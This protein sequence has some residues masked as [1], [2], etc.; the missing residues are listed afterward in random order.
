MDGSGPDDQHDAFR[1]VVD[2]LCVPNSDIGVAALRDSLAI[3]LGR[4]IAYRDLDERCVEL[5]QIG[6]GGGLARKS[7]EHRLANR[8]FALRDRP[9]QAPASRFAPRQSCS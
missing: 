7:P 9:A 8:G 1:L 5:S 2:Q 4:G 3:Q 6:L